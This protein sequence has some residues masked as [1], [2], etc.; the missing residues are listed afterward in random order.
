MFFH[1][2][3]RGDPP[4]A[5]KPRLSQQRQPMK[6]KVRVSAAA[7]MAF[8]PALPFSEA[9]RVVIDRVREL[10]GLP[11]VERVDL[12]S[13]AGR[14]LAGEVKADRDYP[15]LPRSVRDGFAL[16]SSDTP[17]VVVRIGEVRAGE[18]F[19][20]NVEQGQTVEI[21]TG[22]PVPDGADAVVMIEHV[23]VD[24]D[25]VAVGASVEKGANFTPSGAEARVGEPVLRPGMRLGFPEIAMAAAVG[26][27]SLPVYA[28][29]HVAILSTGDEVVGTGEHVEPYQIRNSNAC[30]LAVQVKRA[31]GEPT[32]LPVARDTLDATAA[33]LEQALCGDMVLLSGGVSAGKY[34]V[35]EP[36]LAR[37][38]AEFYFDRALIQPGQPVVFGRACN[39]FFFGLP[40]NPASTMVC[41]EVFAR[42][43][44]E[45][46]SGAEETH[47]PI[48]EAALSA[49]FRHKPG[50][51]RFLPAHLNG[52]GSVTPIRWSGSGDI[53]ATV[54]ANCFLVADPE[55]P[56]YSKGERIGILLK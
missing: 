49:D 1:Q 7:K 17:G 9:R 38:G 45:L 55:K 13:A 6:H 15:P 2:G 50:L 41:F 40:G 52:D 35:V 5:N 11:A 23:Q 51:T 53:A 22:A 18:R 26:C 31:G 29:P 10:R 4:L 16:R 54:R 34:D 21:M 30:S 27:T 28:R 32:I 36:A 39:R 44:L 3:Q 56:E 14:V 19:G 24:G 48:T 33:L 47:L 42:A 37:F 12:I 43:A 25:L 8:V 46:L 20:G